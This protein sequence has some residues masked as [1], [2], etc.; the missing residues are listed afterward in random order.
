MGGLLDSQGWI[1][2]YILMVP[3]LSEDSHQNLPM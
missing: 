2:M 3:S 1:G